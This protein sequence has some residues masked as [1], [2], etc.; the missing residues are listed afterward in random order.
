MPGTHAAIAHVV[1]DSRAP[2]P[3]RTNSATSGLGAVAVRNIAETTRSAWYNVVIRNAPMRPAV[4]PGSD[5]KTLATF[6]VIG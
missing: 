6:S 2:A 5:P 1:H 3:C 4:G